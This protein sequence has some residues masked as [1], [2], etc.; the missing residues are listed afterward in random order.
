MTGPEHY[1]AAEDLLNNVHQLLTDL[2]QDQG[3]NADLLNEAKEILPIALSAAQAHATL[4]QAA[5]TALLGAVATT[6]TPDRDLTEWV[7]VAGA[8]R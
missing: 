1:K 7:G 8:S 3:R 5:A 2:M 6:D 4:A